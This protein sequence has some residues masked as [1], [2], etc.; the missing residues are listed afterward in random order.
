L[1]YLLSE[2]SAVLILDQLD[3]LRWTRS[4]SANSLGVCKAIVRE[5]RNL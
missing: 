3:A 2:T 4:H 1:K 5:L